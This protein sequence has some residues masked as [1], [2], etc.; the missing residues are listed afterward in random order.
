MVPSFQGQTN[1]DTKP[2]LRQLSTESVFDEVMS[3]NILKS[4]KNNLYLIQ[5]IS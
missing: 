3:L 2:E 4:E 1:I 5:E